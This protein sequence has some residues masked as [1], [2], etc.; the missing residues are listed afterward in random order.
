MTDFNYKRYLRT[1]KSTALSRSIIAGAFGSK[2]YRENGG[3]TKVKFQYGADGYLSATRLRQIGNVDILQ[4]QYGHLTYILSADTDTGE[5]VHSVFSH[6]STKDYRAVIQEKD[7]EHF[8][9][10]DT[11]LALIAEVYEPTKQRIKH[12]KYEY[13]CR[14]C[15]VSGSLSS[16]GYE[17]HM[18]K[19][20]DHNVSRK[21]T[22]TVK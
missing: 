13:M 16:D 22:Y 18:K 10:A 5:F 12:L 2:E 20:P 11:A 21:I 3:K 9:L 19:N 6:R 1:P 17:L 8:N 15:L 4:L 7:A 14:N